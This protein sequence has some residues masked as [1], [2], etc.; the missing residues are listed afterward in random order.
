MHFDGLSAL[1]RAS[2][3]HSFG[4]VVQSII[5]PLKPKEKHLLS[6]AQGIMLLLTVNVKS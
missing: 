5:D 1:Q 2:L 6:N 4:R 3:H